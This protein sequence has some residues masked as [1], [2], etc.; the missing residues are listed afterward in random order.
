MTIAS[1]LARRTG[2]CSRYRGSRSMPTDTKNSTANASRMGRASDAARE[3]VLGSSDHHPSEKRAQGHRDAEELGRREGDADGEHEHGQRE[4]LARAGCRDAI[5]H[6]R[7]RARPDDQRER[8]QGRNLEPGQAE[9]QREAGPRRGSARAE[10]ERQDYEDDHREQILDHEPSDGDV[11]SRRM[12]P[13][14][15]G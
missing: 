8:N 2:A 12:K 11:A 3:A 1:V 15:I 10:Q 6:P 14:E 9:R 4:E 7:D 13:S 5:E